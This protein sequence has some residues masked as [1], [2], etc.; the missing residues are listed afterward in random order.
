M[1]TKLVLSLLNAGHQW[2]RQGGSWSPGRVAGST[3][4]LLISGLLA[5]G[6][7]DPRA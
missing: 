5:P 4:A 2:Y 7:A 3:R 6:V 1:A